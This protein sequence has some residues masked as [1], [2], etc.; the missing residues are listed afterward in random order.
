M[1]RTPT[2]DPRVDQVLLAVRDPVRRFVRRLVGP[3]RV[4]DLTSAVVLALLEKCRDGMAPDRPVAYALRIAW[5]RIVDDSRRPAA[6]SLGDQ[7]GFLDVAGPDPSRLRDLREWIEAGLARSSPADRALLHLVYDEGLDH[8]AVA[9]V[10]DCKVGTIGR[11][12]HE[13]RRRLG[14]T[15][16]RIGGSERVPLALAFLPALGR[17]TG[18]AVDVLTSASVDGGISLAAAGTAGVVTMKKLLVLF[19]VVLLGLT[20]WWGLMASPTP[21]PLVGRTADAADDAADDAAM[22]PSPA[23]TPAAPDGPVVRPVSVTAAT[24]DERGAILGRVVDLRGAPI[25][26]AR[27]SVFASGRRPPVAIGAAER[28]PS[29]PLATAVTDASG[30]FVITAPSAARAFDVL[31]TADGF[32]VGIKDLVRADGIETTIVLQAAFRIRGVVSDL[33]GHPIAD[34]TVTYRTM[35]GWT[36]VTSRT[37]TA[38]DGTY[39]VDGVPATALEPT[40]DAHVAFDAP[41]FAP[42]ARPLR[43]Q[44]A[45]SSGVVTLDVV[46]AR[47]GVVEGVVFDRT[48]GR[49]IGGADVVFWMADGPQ[50]TRYIR[51]VGVRNAFGS[52]I[53]QRTRADADGRYRFDRIPVEVAGIKLP[54]LSSRFVNGRRVIGGV[55][56][57]APGHA[58][59]SCPVV[60]PDG[61]RE[62]QQVSIALG[63]CLRITGRVVD[64]DGRPVAGVRVFAAPDDEADGDEGRIVPGEG[65]P[66]GGAAVTDAEGRYEHATVAVPRASSTSIRLTACGCDTS[67]P[68]HPK[69]LVP[70]TGRDIEAPDLVF[71]MGRDRV[72]GA[73]V[74]EAGTPIA[75]AR[76]EAQSW[77]STVLTDAAGG[78]TIVVDRGHRA[79]AS[80]SGTTSGEAVAADTVRASASGFV[81]TDVPMGAAG[82]PLRIVLSRGLVVSGS[83]VTAAG[84]PVAGAVVM[85]RGSPKAEA[86]TGRRMGLRY[87]ASDARGQFRI[88]DLAPGPIELC[89]QA[90]G[91]GPA[92]KTFEISPSSAP[93]VLTIGAT[94]TPTATVR[95]TVT[96]G[97][98]GDPVL[99]GL[100][101]ELVSGSGGGRVGQVTGPGI[102]EFRG[103]PVG[104]WTVHVWAP[105]A[106]RVA[107]DGIVVDGSRPI[108]DV[109][110]R[111]G[112]GG[113]LAGHVLDADGAVPGGT[114]SVVVRR[115]AVE[116]RSTE[117]AVAADGAFSVR[118]L[119]PGDWW[120][121]ARAVSRTEF[122]VSAPSRITVDAVGARSVELRILAT[123]P[124]AL[125]FEYRSN[126]DGTLL[127][128]T[129]PILRARFPGVRMR[130]E[131]AA[132][133]VWHDQPLIRFAGM[134]CPTK[135]T[136]PA[137]PG[138]WRVVVTHG[139]ATW[140]DAQVEVPA[141][142]PSLIRVRIP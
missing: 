99:A 135:L 47:G 62:V 93:I 124:M 36:P 87:L 68:G 54:A 86:E 1:A 142:E 17:T 91:V 103:T 106:M 105:H 136:L 92:W 40:G 80:I 140:A 3:D 119:E 110:V 137:I 71:T 21:S 127:S 67:L 19:G 113:S 7:D 89:A 24:L 72:S 60:M 64:P 20:A 141:H 13:A 6:L 12:V 46:L 38:A 101:A 26:G 51:G 48:S 130:V 23:T 108:I 126:A 11:R 116:G 94:A 10:L 132:G 114:V 65:G 95:V 104:T 66:L 56:A 33:G 111:L 83:V 58:P 131:D 70:A 121:M 29:P 31:A 138:S 41:G 85:A 30:R 139:S 112:V 118:G 25:S 78:F 53:A 133:V 117:V 49:P 8:A 125:A 55:A 43:P 32:A 63:A 107:R 45:H 96:D 75:G 81:T 5:H 122:R 14:A 123:T 120:V 16:D 100:E 74:D 39:S 18:R 115:A 37:T 88:E 42:Q 129:D 57:I 98:T 82:A 22:P 27:L 34:A 52:R 28:E 4:E 109:A 44:P 77:P 61:E 69:L 2:A 50:G 84:E 9:R 76:I 73:V 15:L 79:S 97:T 90:D 128:A 35:V 134:E 59:R 102:V